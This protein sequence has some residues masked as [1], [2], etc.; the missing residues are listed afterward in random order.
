MPYVANGYI[1]LPFV[2]LE[3]GHHG[4]SLN[5]ANWKGKH[6]RLAAQKTDY[7]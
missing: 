6:A 2:C 5:N 1:Q 3:Q 7:I 4:K